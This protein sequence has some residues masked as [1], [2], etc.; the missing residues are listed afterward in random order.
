M[1]DP[2]ADADPDEAVTVT[3]VG[4]MTLRRAVHK[5]EDWREHHGLGMVLVYRES[6]KEPSMFE[7]V[8]L[9]RLAEMER[10]R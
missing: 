2:Y 1:A 5:Y 6:G 7:M 9:S 4:P 10:F 3:G 8:D